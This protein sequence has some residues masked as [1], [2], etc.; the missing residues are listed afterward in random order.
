MVRNRILFAVLSVLIVDGV[1]VSANVAAGGRIENAVAEIDRHVRRDL[2]EHGQATNAPADDA[3]FVRRVYLDVLGRIPT[4]QEISEFY[5]SEDVERRARLID[6]LLESDGHRSHMFN[7][8]ADMLRVKDEYY[9]TGQTYTFHSWI[10]DQLK[11]NRPWDEMVYEMLTA[12]GRLGENG[13][14]G[15]LLRD[16]GMPLDSLSGTLTIFLGA[17]VS[18]AQCHDHPFAEWTQRDFYEMAAFFGATRFERDDPRKPARVMGD[19]E[20]SK[21]NLVTLLRPNMARVMYEEGRWLTFPKDYVYDDVEPG[22]SVIPEFITWGDTDSRTVKVRAHRKQQLRR[23]FAD[24]MVSADNPRFATA[25][26]NRLWKRFFGAAVQE[27]VTD[28]DERSQATNPQLMQFLTQLM[29]AVDFDLREFQRILLNTRTFQQQ[30]SSVPDEG[31]AFRFPG[32]L[33]RRMTAEQAW[34]SAVV[35]VRG[36]DIDS[37]RTDH[38]ELMR[39]LVLPGD[40][41][42]DPKSLVHRKDEIFVFARSLVGENLPGTNRT[43]GR[44]LFLRVGKPRGDDLWIR[45]SEL[46]QPADPSHFLRIAGQSARDVADD[47]STEG[48]ITEALAFMNGELAT[49][50]IGD[51]SLV[52]RQVDGATRTEDQV[53]LLYHSFLSRDPKLSEQKLAM[54]ALRAGMTTADLAWALL[55]SRE[56][57]FIQ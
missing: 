38:A 10:K 43:K 24:W 6:Q 25:I 5:A 46:P 31:V 30:A 36:S 44:G 18:C 2:R 13:A 39:R 56:F 48:G 7:W 40:G 16:A 22:Q 47:G 21:A 14:T 20:F 15:Y 11:A 27:P 49:R 26:A 33:L 53:R 41:A 4:T 34:D 50:V 3:Q 9:R 57:L 29:T 23:Q 45:A 52:M 37:H 55:N 42:M 12:R 54:D 51:R 28:L 1:W 19:Q 8:L 17:N 35:L 32:P